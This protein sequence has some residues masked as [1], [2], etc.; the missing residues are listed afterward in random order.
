MKPVSEFELADLAVLYENKL[1]WTKAQGVKQQDVVAELDRRQRMLEAAE[2]MA[3]SL[4][5]CAGFIEEQFCR[6]HTFTDR[7][8]LRKELK[9]H[10]LLAP[11]REFLA[12]YKKAKGK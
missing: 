5:D 3:E 12:A 1:S 2:G 6:V 9:D 8:T 7:K 10:A 11:A 4:A